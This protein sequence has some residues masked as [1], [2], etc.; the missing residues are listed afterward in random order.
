MYDI[1]HKT[2]QYEKETVLASNS[3]SKSL[4]IFKSKNI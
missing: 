3:K 4:E 1:E 2:M